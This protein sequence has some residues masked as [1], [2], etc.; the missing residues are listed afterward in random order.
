MHLKSAYPG[1]TENFLEK[2]N[3]VIQANLHDHELDIGKLTRLVNMGRTSLFRKI[4]SLTD[5]TPNEL[6]NLIR[7]KKA[8]HLLSEGDYRIFEVADMVGFSSQTNFGR[9][10]YQHYGQTPKEF[11]KN[12]RTSK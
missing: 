3:E 10:F 1:A 9:K 6:I 12:K 5:L 2:L 7:L 4:K 8:A 11:Q